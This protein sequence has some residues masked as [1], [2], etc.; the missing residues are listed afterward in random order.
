MAGPEDIVLIEGV[1]GVMVPLNDRRTV[2]DW[3]EALGIP[4][5]LVIGTYLGSI[6][7]TLTALTALRQRQIP[8]RALIINESEHSVAGTMDEMRIWTDAP[9]FFVKRRSIKNPSQVDELLPL[10]Q[11]A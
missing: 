10:M 11:S 6:S 4:V 2:L 7:H 5:L 9:L 1:G 3:I 8:I